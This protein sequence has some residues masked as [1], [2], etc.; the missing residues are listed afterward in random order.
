MAGAKELERHLGVTYKTAWRIAKQIR[1]MMD[2]HNVD[3][4][5]IVEIDETYVGGRNPWHLE[6]P[7]TAIMGVVERG[8]RVEA[9]VTSKPT[10]KVAEAFIEANVA[11]GAE[12]HT[13]ES[14]IYK[15]VSGKRVHEAINHSR[16]PHAKMRPKTVSV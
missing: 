3:L 2:E 8:G 5:G 12:V 6:K 1:K 7:K 11:S 4:S 10:P 9:Q 15:H 16:S 14:T 13:D